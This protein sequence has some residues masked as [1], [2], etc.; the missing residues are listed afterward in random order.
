MKFKHRDDFL[1]VDYDLIENTD[2]SFFFSFFFSH[3][4]TITPRDSSRPSTA[5]S[6]A[7][8]QEYMKQT[9]IVR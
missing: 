9:G 8:R 2:T 4:G 1:C 3:T 6:S 5:R 7:A